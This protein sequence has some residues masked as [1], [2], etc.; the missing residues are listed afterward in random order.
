MDNQ[1]T[2][3]WVLF[4]SMVFLTWTKWRTDNAPPPEVAVSSAQSAD[5]APQIALSELPEGPAAPV[6]SDL[7][8]LPAPAG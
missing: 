6:D 4:A 7:A 8:N 1:R 2:I 5:A 3:L